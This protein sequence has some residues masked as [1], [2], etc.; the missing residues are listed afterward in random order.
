M[1]P[2]PVSIA[3]N[4]PTPALVFAVIRSDGYGT[5]RSDRGNN[6]YK[7]VTNHSLPGK[8]GARHYVN[9][10]QEKDVTMP[11]GLVQKQ[12]ASVSLSFSSPVY[13]F[14]NADLVAL[15]KLLKDYVDDS[16][17][18]ATLLIGGES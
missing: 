11:S 8:S 14:T 6:G 2:D 7:V 4:S 10:S 16:E 1:L 12:K 5:E 3:A 15:W 17:V 18:T 13:G 9:I